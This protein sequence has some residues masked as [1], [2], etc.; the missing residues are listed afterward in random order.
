MEICLS[1]AAGDIL[2]RKEMREME[3]IWKILPLA[4]LGAGAR[5][6]PQWSVPSPGVLASRQLCQT[7]HLALEVIK[8]AHFLTP[9][10][11]LC[12]G[13]LLYQFLFRVIFITLVYLWGP[14]W[15]VIFQAW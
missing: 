15:E 5:G 13:L 11:G 8:T 4:F 3:S 14:R 7:C 9:S 6:C 10:C 12:L 2:T 1:V